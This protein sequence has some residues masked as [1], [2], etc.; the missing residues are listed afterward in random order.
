M[1]LC[2]RCCIRQHTLP[3]SQGRLTFL[4]V[5]CTVY[6]CKL[7]A[8]HGSNRRVEFSGLTGSMLLTKI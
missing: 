2:E 3:L 4:P 5:A 1:S 7:M 8:S 6:G